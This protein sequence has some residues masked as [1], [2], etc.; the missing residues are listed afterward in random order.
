[1]SYW[2][3]G[4]LLSSRFGKP[5]RDK[6]VVHLF[7]LQ[8]PPRDNIV[9]HVANVAV[10][11]ESDRHRYRD[12]NTNDPPIMAG[13]IRCR[14]FYRES[15]WSHCEPFFKPSLIT[16]AHTSNLQPSQNQPAKAGVFV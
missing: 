12:V 2:R 6:D 5:P 11:I 10:R 9:G 8:G 7:R 13:E 15:V 1:M 16:D 4:K 3:S 14:G